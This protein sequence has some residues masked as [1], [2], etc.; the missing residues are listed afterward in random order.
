MKEKANE[1]HL[2][3]FPSWLVQGCILSSTRKGGHT[4][5]NAPPR[6]SD[7]SND[8]PTKHLSPPSATDRPSSHHSITEKQKYVHYDE[9]IGRLKSVVV[10]LLR[11]GIGRLESVSVG[12][13]IHLIIISHRLCVVVRVQ[14]TVHVIGK[15]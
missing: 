3:G 15:R 9:D 13:G 6:R 1:G 14:F 12:R 10:G 2:T 11:E 4:P 8:I 7:F 5:A